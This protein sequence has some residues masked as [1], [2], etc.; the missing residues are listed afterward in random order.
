VHGILPLAQKLKM[1]FGELT[2]KLMFLTHA[3]DRL[4]IFTHA[5]L[6]H[7]LDQVPGVELKVPANHDLKT[8]TP[9]S[10]NRFYSQKFEEIKNSLQNFEN[11][12]LVIEDEQG[13]YHLVYASGL[14]AHMQKEGFE[15]MTFPVSFGTD[16]KSFYLQWLNMAKS[17]GLVSLD[18]KNEFNLETIAEFAAQIKN[19]K[20]FFSI[21]N[22]HYLDQ[23]DQEDAQKFFNAL[24]EAF[25]GAPQ[26][27]L[28]TTSV[29]AIPESI[30]D[31]QALVYKLGAL[32][33]E[34]D[35]KHIEQF[36]IEDLKKINPVLTLDLNKKVIERLWQ[37]SGE[38]TRR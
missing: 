37:M 18:A 16:F 38:Q 25:K 28:L 12:N 23:M 33:G 3:G 1:T 11:T 17:R 14:G 22:L 29:P 2:E 19:Q 5:E 9:T 15:V 26:S 10:L 20:I 24:N 6:K 34:R 4:Q 31:P 13:I 32:N 8:E 35:W 30:K 7:I 21:I 27:R 36:V